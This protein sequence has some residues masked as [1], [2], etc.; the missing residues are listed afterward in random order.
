MSKM[1]AKLRKSRASQVHWSISFVL[2]FI[3]LYLGNESFSSKNI[4]FIKK[5]SPLSVFWTIF[6]VI[7]A[8]KTKKTAFEYL[9]NR[10][11]LMSKMEA[12]L[13]KSRP[14]KVH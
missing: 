7:P 3:F 12:K 10:S 11:Q 14:S 13:P 5:E 1:E 8:I 9:H 6:K 2:L 4:L